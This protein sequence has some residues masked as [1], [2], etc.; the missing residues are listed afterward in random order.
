MTSGDFKALF[1]PPHELAAAMVRQPLVALHDLA[2]RLK[3]LASLDSRVLAS[4]NR[5]LR[6]LY[7]TDRNDA[8]YQYRCVH[9]CEQLRAVGV[10]ANIARLHDSNLLDLIPR[11]SVIVLFR[12]PWS[13][14]AAE[15]VAN[16][17]TAGA[18]VAYDVDDLVFDTAAKEAMAFLKRMTKA[19]VAGYQKDS[20]LQATT[21]QRVDFCIVS[22]ERL[23][24]AMRRTGLTALVH[25]NLLGDSQIEQAGRIYAKRE[26]LLQQPCLAY[27]SG[28]NTHDG[29]LASIADALARVLEARS[30]LL[31]LLCGHVIA[32]P[33]LARLRER[34]IQ[35]PFQH[36][37]VYPWIMGRCNAVLAPM[38]SINEF[39]NSKSSL[40]VFEAGILG[41]PTV[42]SPTVEYSRAIRSGESGFLTASLSE[43]EEALH[44]LASREV[45]LSMGKVARQVALEKFSPD[46]H[47]GKLAAL[48]AGRAGRSEGKCPVLQ[49]FESADPGWRHPQARIKCELDLKLRARHFAFAPLPQLAAEKPADPVRPM[50]VRGRKIP[51]TESKIVIGGE[52]YAIENYA[53][54]RNASRIGK[55]Q[56]VSLNRDPSVILRVPPRALA[57][58]HL[59]IELR[60]KTED[61]IAHAQIFW[62]REGKFCEE[63]SLH[64]EIAADGAWRTYFIDARPALFAN[65]SQPC[66]DLFWIRFDPL[67]ATGLFE[68][69]EIAFLAE[70]PPI[71]ERGGRC[72]RFASCQDIPVDIVVPIYN[73]RALTEKCITSVREHA[74]GDWRLV[75][76]DDASTDPDLAP[77]LK[78]AAAS[79]RHIVLL[80]N[81]QNCGFVAT[82]NRGI[83]QASGRDVL[84]LNSDT[85]VFA[86]FLD[87]L[88]A[89]VYGDDFTGIATPFSNNATIYSVPV[90]C[91]DNPI[92]VGYTPAQ[93]AS[94]VQ[95]CS[96]RMRPEMPTA[97]GFCMYV[98]NAVFDQVGVLDEAT[99]GSGYGEENDLCLRARKA[100]WQVRL[101]DDVFVFHKGRGSFGN[102]AA[103]QLA[104]NEEALERKHP[105]YNG[106]IARFVESNP[107]RRQHDEIRFHLERYGQGNGAAVLYIL[108]SSPFHPQAGGT[109][110]HVLDLLKSM[111]PP[112]AVLAYPDRGSLEFAEILRGEVNQAVFYRFDLRERPK[113]FAV[114]HR[115]METALRWALSRFDIG[116]A[117]IHHL[118]FWPL[119]LGRI[120][121]D[122]DVPYVFT[123]HDYYSA[124][125]SWNLFD[126]SRRQACLG[127]AACAGDASCLVALCRE[128]CEF[129]IDDP[130]SLARGVRKA[131]SATLAAAQ[132]IIFPSTT[133]RDTALAAFTFKPR[134]T[135]VIEHGYD[136]TFSFQEPRHLPGPLRVAIVGE[137][138]HPMKGAE[139]Y[140]DLISDLQDLPIAWHFFGRTDRFRLE[141]RLRQCAPAAKLHFHGPYKRDGIVSLLR[142][143]DIDLYV[144]L[145]LWSETFSYTLSEALLAGVPA[146]VDSRG[147][148]IA[149]RVR[150]LDVGEVVE[151]IPAA[152]AFLRRLC[153]D[154]SWLDARRA[155][156]GRLEHRTIETSARETQALYQQ[157]GIWP[158]SGALRRLDSPL[159]RTIAAYR[160]ST[161]NS[162]AGR[163]A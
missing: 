49:P 155:T 50:V 30:D 4:P 133:A 86:G 33:R 48:L 112:R 17:K 40:K 35:I 131:S 105:G 1:P 32:P 24:Q 28:S 119:A 81:K 129:E 71:I 152:A 147:G 141:Q 54:V 18:S 72:G 137:I 79:D 6:V 93:F 148:A 158:P 19:Q 96:L 52:G 163:K 128:L 113:R 145:P 118:M 39:T 3:R 108:H 115:E 63:G 144:S 74:T 94:L 122:A 91:R 11:Y 46:A 100:G 67:A 88:R 99:F 92:P 87:K 47:A 45:S 69:G 55:N 97:V 61:P 51:M 43:W 77:Y 23:A 159:V 70:S 57:W 104:R 130:V 83:Q 64:F 22:T 34:V 123:A 65:K 149:E 58:G 66:Q 14:R 82:A 151:D 7:V 80:T 59:A 117:H 56:W 121:Q 138:A 25:P 9:A 120:L 68:L 85:E 126:F 75:L 78:Q 161:E 162:S 98:R 157:K 101:A 37:R 73:A 125:I 38:E 8:P 95:A 12:L 107:L 160:V 146:L 89:C 90:F 16:A 53:E 134:D 143:K 36:P 42:A 5:E 111:R 29:D 132:A 26:R 2:W 153:A 84:L 110:Y 136:A 156:I 142:A 60:V 13:S 106:E 102:P 103:T 27:L 139:N 10:P 135:V 140:L 20:K 41:V 15:V 114:H 31:L 62:D 109:E 21:V 127:A 154:R 76:I 44:Q 116:A 124:C 150:R